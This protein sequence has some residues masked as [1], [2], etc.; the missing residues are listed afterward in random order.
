[1][2]A[3]KHFE[4]LDAI[5][6]AFEARL[7]PLENLQERW[8]RYPDLEERWRRYPDLVQEARQLEFYRKIVAQALTDS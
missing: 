4:P 5:L 6:Q 8:R 1:M 3:E 7:K 2:L